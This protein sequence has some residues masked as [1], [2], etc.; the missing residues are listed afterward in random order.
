MGAVGTTSEFDPLTLA[1]DSQRIVGS[2]MGS[3]NI[4]RDIPNLV[5]LYRQG[6]LELDGLITGRYRLEDI[7][8]AIASVNAGEAL[9]NVIVF[10]H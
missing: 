5:D 9:R 7:N 2:K 3:S 1:N 4:Q 6:R 10:D 8:E